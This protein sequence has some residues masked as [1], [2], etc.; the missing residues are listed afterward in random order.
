MPRIFRAAR[1][2]DPERSFVPMSGL[3][4]AA[5][6]TAP[7][8][9]EALL[10]PYPFVP[11]RCPHPRADPGGHGVL[12]NDDMPAAEVFRYGV[13]LFNTRH[14]WEAHE[15]WERLWRSAAPRSS[16]HDAL[17]GLIQL[18]ASLLVLFMGHQ[19]GCRRLAARACGL[20]ERASVVF[21][22]YREVD[23]RG[24][25]KAARCHILE[26]EGLLEFEAA[27]FPLPLD[28]R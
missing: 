4:P 3:V 24:A 12:A 16:E 2:P 13:D 5:L 7:R 14:Y 17:K 6:A 11:G 25:I 27:A 23:L 20:L 28:R 8:L 21:R 26:V 15:A 10:P 9:T 19:S 18:S 1:D 22:T